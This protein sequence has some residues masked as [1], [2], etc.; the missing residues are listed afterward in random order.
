[1]EHATRRA[2]AGTITVTLTLLGWS[3][4]PLFLHHFAG[5]I[6]AWTS[7][8]W[9]Y[10]FSALCWAPLL[11]FM[12]LRGGLPDGLWRAAL[13][14]S[15][16]NAAGQIAFCQGLYEIDPGLFTFGLRTQLIFT[17]VGAYVLFPRERRVIRTGW[18]VAGATAVLSG[19]TLAVVGGGVTGEGNLL[20]GIA[21][22]IAAGALFA[23]Y[24]LAVRRN[25]TAYNPVVAFAAISQLTTVP[26]VAL[27]LALG[28]RAGAAALDLPAGEMSL[29]LLSAVIGIALG[30]V[31]YY[32][33]IARLGVAIS[34]GVLQLHPFMVAL[35]SM[36]IFT[37]VLRPAQWAGGA[38]ALAGA[39]MMLAVQG[40][41]N[42]PAAAPTIMPTES[43]CGSD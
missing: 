37:E 32:V 26:L 25:M 31:L 16:F 24:A 23:A 43:P 8:G 39:V 6:D 33:S 22:S 13:L 42:A 10:G 21:L 18:Y 12:H 27:M 38:V 35:G 36:M 34:S 14:P 1:M 40:R 41:L 28:D 19:T 4:V 11:V 30:H 3:S 2:L 5:S 29:L 20:A 7:N 15:V 9:R 17:A